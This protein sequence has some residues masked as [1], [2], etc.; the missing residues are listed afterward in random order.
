MTS[1]CLFMTFNNFDEIHLVPEL[2]KFSP[3]M[4]SHC[5][6]MTCNNFDEIHLVPEL[7]KF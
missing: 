2:E 5:L 3:T 4:T 1:H 6:F 7:E